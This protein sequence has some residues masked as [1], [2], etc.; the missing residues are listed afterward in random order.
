MNHCTIRRGERTTRNEIHILR[1]I[2]RE[3]GHPNLPTLMSDGYDEL[4]TSQ[5]G[6]PLRPGQKKTDWAQ[7]LLGVLDALKWLHSH[8]II[9]RDVRWENIKW[10]DDHAVLTDLGTS[11][12]LADEYDGTITYNGGYICCPRDLIGDFQQAYVALPSDDCYAF[13]L[14]VN[15]LLWPAFWADMNPQLVARTHSKEAAKLRTFWD[16][17]DSSPFFKK[18]MEAAENLDYDTLATLADLCVYY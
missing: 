2:T 9:H 5:F 14:L 12:Q 10:D 7:V 18:Y 17:M 6:A 16:A 3:G 4:V 13:V 11:V 15:M 8:D 1:Y